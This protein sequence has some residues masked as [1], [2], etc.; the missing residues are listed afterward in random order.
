MNPPCFH[1]RDQACGGSGFSLHVADAA[2]SLSA[3]I[4]G[5]QDT[6]FKASDARTEGHD[7]SGT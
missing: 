7:V 1:R 4:E 6:E 5:E 2:T 3:M